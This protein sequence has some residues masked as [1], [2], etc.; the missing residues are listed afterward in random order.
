MW[1]I[2]IKLANF[3]RNYVKFCERYFIAFDFI[4]LSNL[5]PNPNNLFEILSIT[6]FLDDCLM[7]LNIS[8]MACY[9][10]QNLPCQDQF[11]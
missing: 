3:T 9:E 11:L 2:L 8:L 1:R 7:C 5:N 10:H 4:T 6:A